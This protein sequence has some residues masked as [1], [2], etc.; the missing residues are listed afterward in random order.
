[1]VVRRYAQRAAATGVAEVNRERLRVRWLQ[2]G[3]ADGAVERVRRGRVRIEIV[4]RRP[5]D[6][7]RVQEPHGPPGR[8]VVRDVEARE[9]RVVRAVETDTADARRELGV[10]Q[11]GTQTQLCRELAERATE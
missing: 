1:A 3:V 4:G 5:G 2:V 10:A 7:L 9:E 6:A 8:R 11:L